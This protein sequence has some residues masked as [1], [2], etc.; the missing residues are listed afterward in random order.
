MKSGII[1]I[2][3]VSIFSCVGLPLV[4]DNLILDNQTTYPKMQNS[5]IAIQWAFSAKEVDEGNMA[6]IHGMSLSAQKL[7]PLKQSGKVSVTIPK[8]AEYFRVLIWSQGG[9]DPD[10][11]TNWV[12]IVSDKTYQLKQDHLI[13]TVLISGTGC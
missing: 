8:N 5:K 12:N 4:A 10:F 2:I 9:K 11:H 13:P 1:S 7:Q 3:L 6:L